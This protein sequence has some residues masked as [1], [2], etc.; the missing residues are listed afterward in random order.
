[1]EA[2]VIETEKQEHESGN[3]ALLDS[4][5]R[6]FRAQKETAPSEIEKAKPIDSLLTSFDAA[7]SGLE[8]KIEE[9]RK[10][11]A[12]IGPRRLDISAPAPQD[13]PLTR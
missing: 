9:S 8:Q 3:F 7:V 4:F 13:G 10:A 11:M 2:N 1:M 5:A 6:L 12:P